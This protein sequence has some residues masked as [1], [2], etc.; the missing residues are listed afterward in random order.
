MELV[1]NRKMAERRI[2]PAI[3]ITLS[4]TRREEQ[5]YD[6]RTYRAVITMRRMFSQLADQQGLEAM[7]AFMQQMA[8]T[9]SNAEFLA[10]LARGMK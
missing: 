3:D 6:D 9:D 4:G 10:T 7:E 8:K 1:L 2:F 5:L